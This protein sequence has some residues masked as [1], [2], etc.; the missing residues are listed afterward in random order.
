MWIIG[1]DF[2]P[3]FQ[4]I[5]YVDTTTGECGCMR[6]AHGNGEAERFYRHL[7]GEQ[8]RVGMEAT[9]CFRW[10][11]R[12]LAELGQELWRGDAARIRA[13]AAHKAKTDKRD[14]ELLRQLLIE[15]RF[16]RIWIPSLEQRDARQLIL[17]RHRLV[18]IRTRIKNQVQA[19]AMNEGL[20]CK[21]RLWSAEGRQELMQLELSP[22]GARRREDLLA[23]LQQMNERLEPLDQAVKVAAAS[24]PEA[25]R[26]MSH[27]GVGPIVSLAYV[28]TMGDPHRFHN[29][30]QV[31]A[32]F[33]LVPKE[34][35]SG[36]HQRLGHIT[37]QG[38]ALLRGLLVEAA[39]IA[40]RHDDGLR[41]RYLRLAF[42]KSRSIATVAIARHLA[43][44][45]WWMWKSGLDYGQMLRSCSH[46]E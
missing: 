2:H 24:R 45:L 39:H 11:Q 18:Q 36:G 17:H 44:R 12:L 15:Q 6:L 30:R 7:A 23:L 33:G 25:Q 14:A 34:Q 31:A 21:H 19:L 42:K 46:A 5:A 35:S 16:P 22:W 20:Q 28:L 3:G 32:Y 10:F 41:R 26:L 1:C 9:G 27:P 40:I 13:A 43:V 37:K 38:N 4:Q 29:S 8:V